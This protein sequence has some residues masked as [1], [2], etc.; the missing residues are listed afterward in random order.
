MHPL[1]I[2]FFVIV[3]SVRLYP[4]LRR[5]ILAKKIRKKEQ[6]FVEQ[7][8]ENC[9]III[10]YGKRLKIGNWIFNKK[11]IFTG[12][13]NNSD[14]SK[15]GK[16]ESIEGNFT[17]AIPQKYYRILATLNFHYSDPTAVYWASHRIHTLEMQKETFLHK[18]CVYRI[19]LLEG[20]DR[21]P[22][23]RVTEVLFMKKGSIPSEKKRKTTIE[24]TI[25]FEQILDDKYG[26]DFTY[27]SNRPK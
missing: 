10:F 1:I 24:Y 22:K 8:I 2:Y 3:L 26:K 11:N 14:R 16:V 27:S 25:V 9:A 7:H 17:I 5:I 15:I 4:D 21:K 23:K 6:E 13:S 19:C 18:G 12:K 20:N